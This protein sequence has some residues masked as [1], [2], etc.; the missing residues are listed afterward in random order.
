MPHESNARFHPNGR[1]WCAARLLAI[2]EITAMR[3]LFATLCITAIL[4]VVSGCGGEK[5]KEAP[6]TTPTTPAETPAK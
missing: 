1:R 5:A 4:A 6:K 2:Q 3:K